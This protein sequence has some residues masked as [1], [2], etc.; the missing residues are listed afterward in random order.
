MIQPALET[1]SRAIFSEKICVY[2]YLIATY[3][4]LHIDFVYRL[5]VIEKSKPESRDFKISRNLVVRRPS[6]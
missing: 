1:I 2:F 5:K 6:P 3:C 4:I